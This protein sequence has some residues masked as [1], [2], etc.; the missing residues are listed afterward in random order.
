MSQ[1][2]LDRKCSNPVETHNHEETPKK[3]DKCKHPH[4]NGVW[5]NC[6]DCDDAGRVLRDYSVMRA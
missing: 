5:V 6:N 1:T 4:V 2:M 3:G